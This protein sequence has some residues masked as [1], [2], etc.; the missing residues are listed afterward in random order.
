MS[1]PPL[2]STLDI[3]GLS[4]PWYSLLM[5]IAVGVGIFLSMREER[6]LSLP[7][8]TILNFALLAIPLGVIGA[9]LYYVAFTWSR[10]QSN[11]LEI[12]R[13][14]NGGLAIYGA[15][16]GGLLAAL[17]ISFTSKVSL[18]TLVDAAAPSLVLGQAIGRWGNYANMEAYGSRLYSEAFQFFP[19]AVEIRLLGANGTEY[20]YWHMATFFYE[21]IWC[22]LIFI[23]LMAYRK[24]MK[25]SGDVFFWYLLLY[26]VGRTVIEG[27]RDDSLLLNVAAA[28]VRIS[29]ILSAAACLGVLIFFFLRLKKRRKL[30][31]AEALCWS[32]IVAG[33]VCTFMGEFERN[34][35][36]MLFLPAQLCLG[37]LLLVDVVFF[38]HYI[39]RAKRLYAPAIWMLTAASLCILTLLLGIGR[40]GGDNV[41]FITLRQWVAMLHLILAG[42]WFYLR[43]G[44]EKRRGTRHANDEPIHMQEA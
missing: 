36:Q 15:V 42:A 9:R 27:L 31:L 20:W 2:G 17:I 32:G 33:I 39:K 22:L 29:Q 35:Y 37:V 43:T 16:L 24:K 5:M 11:P 21:S 7:R 19:L 14:W 10:F 25:R 30:H 41:M 6:R 38:I 23:L 26:C 40:M 34:A 1:R 18:L 28:Q 3:L 8:D 44:N 13:V 12:F 4:M